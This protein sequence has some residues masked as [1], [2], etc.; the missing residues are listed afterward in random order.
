MKKKMNYLILFLTTIL[1][2]GCTNV[3]D[4][5]ITDEETEPQEVTTDNSTKES[6]TD[7]ETNSQ[8]G[9]TS[10]TN[11]NSEKEED[12]TTVVDEPVVEEITNETNNDLFSGYELIEVDGGDLSGDRESSVV[13]DVGYGNREYWA[14]TN[15][16]GQLVRVIAKEIILQ[17]DSTEPV[18]ST[19]RYFSDEAKVPGVESDVLDEGHVIADSLGGVSNAYNITPQESTLNRHGDQA[20]MEDAIRNAGGATNFEAVISYSDTKTQIPSK[21]Q[22]SYT[23]NGN[24]VVDT[25]DNVNPDEVNESLGLTDSNE[26]TSSDN[27]SS[28]E[29]GDV[30]S[31]D[32]NGNGQVTIKEAKAAGFSMPIMSD[33]WLY[34][35]MRDNDGDGMVGE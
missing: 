18:L 1:M 31:V 2:V 22:Y 33:H 25:F 3:E 20:Y 26:S 9:T 32:T 24:E 6:E 27:S 4:A 15:E 35:Y 29:K 7:G 16:N 5:P 19:G 21:Y 34:P 10:N 8:E 30:S 13:V 11:G 14:F 28:E 23:I 17:D 12:T